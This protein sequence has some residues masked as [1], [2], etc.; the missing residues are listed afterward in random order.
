[1]S[2][3][4]NGLMLHLVELNINQRCVVGLPDEVAVFGGRDVIREDVE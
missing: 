1:M 3:L 2:L 4:C